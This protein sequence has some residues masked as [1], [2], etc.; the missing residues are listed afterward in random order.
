MGENK[1]RAQHDFVM[2][3]LP[4]IQGFAFLAHAA[5]NNAWLPRTRKSPG[6]IGQEI[7]H[8][9]SPSPVL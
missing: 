4:M 1:T 6:Y 8:L 9:S 5:E 3:E 2:D 7:Q